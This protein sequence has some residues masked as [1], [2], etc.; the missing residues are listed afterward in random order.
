MQASYKKLQEY[1]DEKLPEPGKLAELLTFHSYEVENIAEKD[2]DYIFDID[3]LPN[4]QGDSSDEAGVAREISAILDISLGSKAPKLGESGLK[5]SVSAHEINK[6]L[7]SQIP[8]KEIGNIFERLGF[9]FDLNGDEF[10]VAIPSERADIKVKAELIE[11]VGRI[12]GYENIEAVLPDKPEKAPRINKKFYYINKIKQFLIKEGFSEVYTYTFRDSGEVEMI[13]PF[14]ADKNFLRTDLRGG[15]EKAL[16]QNIKNLPLL[17][18]DEIKIFEIGNV[19]TKNEEHTSL[20]VVG[21]ID[22]INKLSEFLGVEISE[23]PKEGIFEADLDEIIN[24]LPEP[25]DKYEKFEKKENVVFSS[26]SQYPFVLRD[27][28]VWVPSDVKSDEVLNII[29]KEGTELLVNT[30]LFDEFK[31]DDKV[32]FAFNLVFQSQ[33]KT[34]SDEEINKVMDSVTKAL[35]KQDNWQVR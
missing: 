1:F 18:C 33:E 30:K 16:Y 20:G 23:K 19:F 8:S 11:E 34:L 29:K 9:R 5:I 12:Y 6:L 22:L 10:N 32:S 14:A 2:G 31:K 13:K 25:A 15:L 35:E 7:G 3:V 24:K 27:I 26:I 28:A 21:S 17:D 4:R